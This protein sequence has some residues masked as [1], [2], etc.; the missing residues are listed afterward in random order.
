M[1]SLVLEMP[2][3]DCSDN[4]GYK[5]PF[6]T[7]ELFAFEV[8]SIIDAFFDKSEEKPIEETNPLIEALDLNNN[9]DDM[10][11]LHDED[12]PDK[13]DFVIHSEQDTVKVEEEQKSIPADNEEG[14]GS[15]RKE[16]GVEPVQAVEV[17]TEEVK[18]EV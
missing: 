1:L 18:F 17:D 5:I 11:V 14:G 12:D 6:Q 3:A 7:M 16:E 9:S 15:E 10:I 4:R 2:P 8:S 13:D